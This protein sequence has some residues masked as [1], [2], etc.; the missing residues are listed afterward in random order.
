MGDYLG[1]ALTLEGFLSVQLAIATSDANYVDDNSIHY[2]L[3]PESPS[4][5]S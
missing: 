5:S 1:S 2:E 3:N 4:D